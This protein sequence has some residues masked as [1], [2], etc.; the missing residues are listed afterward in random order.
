MKAI[1]YSLFGAERGRQENCFSFD[2]Y[3]RGLLINIR[4]N[5]LIYPGWTIVLETDQVTNGIWGDL[6]KQL[7]IEVEVNPDNTPLTKSMLWRLK[8]VYHNTFDKWKYTHVLCRDLDSPPTYRE[9][10]AV[11]YW[12]SNNKAMH[13]IT[14]SV[15]HNL[16]LLGGMIGI[17]P[18]FFTERVSKS[19]DSL[20]AQGDYDFSV[21]GADQHFL[22]DIVYPKVASHESGSITQHYFNGHANTFLSDF[23]TCTCPPPSGHREDCPNNFKIDLPDDLKESNTVCGHIGASGWYSTALS[24]FLYKYRGRFS[25]L[26]EVEKQ[27]PSVFYWTENLSF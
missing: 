14:D 5:K 18:D 10:Q 20:M 16:P 4:M 24:K 19:W 6:F 21:K 8:P 12:I 27:Y 26:I 22:N 1:V 9:K 15:S 25:A 7:P 17:R 2:S 13:A 11:E 3:L 23:K